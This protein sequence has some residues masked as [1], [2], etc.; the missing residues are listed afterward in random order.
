MPT[1]YGKNSSKPSQSNRPLRSGGKRGKYRPLTEAQKKKLK[2][3]SEHHST[4]HMN[5]MKRNMRYGISFNEAH[6]K[7]MKK[8]GK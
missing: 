5:A 4:K 2:K 7:A 1:H 8:V 3:H 6:K